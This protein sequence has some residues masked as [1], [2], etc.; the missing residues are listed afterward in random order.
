ML[1]LKHTPKQIYDS[2]LSQLLMF[3]ILILHFIIDP[4]TI[5]IKKSYTFRHSLL[6]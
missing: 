5:Y 6:K 3:S 2:I 1:Y 4:D